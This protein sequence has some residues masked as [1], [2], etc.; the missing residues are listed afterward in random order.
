MIPWIIMAVVV[1]PLAVLAFAASRRKTRKSEALAERDA[2]TARRTEQEFAD[3]ER[4]E[5]E[6]REANRHHDHPVP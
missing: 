5:E 4:F 1:V 3:A 6:W 2:V